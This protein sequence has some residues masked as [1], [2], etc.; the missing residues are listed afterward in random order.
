MRRLSVWLWLAAAFTTL[1]PCQEFEVVSIKPNK[2]AV[3]GSDSDSDQGRFTA[4][5]LSLRNMIVTAY[6]LKDFQ[7]QGP[8]WL[9]S[10]HFDIIAKF[11]EGLPKD[12]EGKS[13]A[14][15][16]MMQKMLAD[17][18]KVVVH[19]DQKTFS[20]YALTV[21]RGGIKFREAPGCD[22]H[23]SNGKS[24]HYTGDCISMG[25]FADFLSRRRAELPADLP[26]LDMTGLKGFYNLTLDWVQESK[27]DAAAV[28]ES[29]SGPL[30]PEAI[31]EQLGLKIEAR[32]APVGILVVDHAERV[33]T[34]N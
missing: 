25:V 8:A 9:G 33:P 17:R 14:M 1:A 19:P 23:S 24:T 22:S 32:K 15:R 16:A 5:S 2:S 18:F 12:R 29:K 34:D 30:L 10:E 26:V 13:A 31:Q 27:G 3:N 28:A 6:G 11:P 21:A 20:V 4:T 7:V